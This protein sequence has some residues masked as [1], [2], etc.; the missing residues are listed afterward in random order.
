MTLLLPR[1]DLR[2]SLNGALARESLFVTVPLPQ[3]GINIHLYWWVNGADQAGR[4]VS[5][6]ADD[7][8]RILFDRQDGI[9]MPGRDFDDW[10][11]AGL[12]VAHR[13]LLHSADFAFESDSLR[14]RF[15]FESLHRAFAYSENANGC[16]PCMADDRFE[17]AGAVRGELSLPG[18]RVVAFDTTG[19]RDHSWGRRDYRSMHH[20]KW[21]STQAGPGC[22]LNAFQL[23][24][25]G[26]QTINGYLF[27][28]AVLAP[29]VAMEN[30]VEYDAVFAPCVLQ[31]RIT[32]SH[33]RSVQVRSRRFS[34]L[35]WEALPIVMDD[36][37]CSSTLD[38]QA[39]V[40]HIGLAWTDAY[41]AAQ[42]PAPR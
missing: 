26:E 8:R 6:F 22:A 38:G 35:R 36:I 23:L 1:D 16:P 40:S 19:H 25:A 17:Q 14:F 2:H 9:A 33:G 39:A 11:V 34:H 42:L 5:V 10:T 29:V 21:V 20:F 18:G 41:L 15:R 28:D 12:N 31:T 27:K 3:E 24:A 4:V 13:E 32:D 30:H 37:G 7:N